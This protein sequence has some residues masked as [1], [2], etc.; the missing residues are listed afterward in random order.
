METIIRR[1]K[2]L[3]SDKRGVSNALVVLLSLILITV[4]VS[5]V[6]IW[7]YQMNQLDWERTNESVKIPLVERDFRL[8][9]CSDLLG[10]FIER[11]TAGGNWLFYPVNYIPIGG[12]QYLSGS[13]SD[14]QNNTGNYLRFGSFASNTQYHL[15]SRDTLYS[16]NSTQYQDY[17]SLT[18]TAENQSDYLILAYIEV[19]HSSSSSQAQVRFVQDDTTLANYL[20]RPRVAN[21]EVM[22][23]MFA[24][25]YRGTGN[26]VNFK[27]QI[28]TSAGGATVT[29]LRGRIYA[30]R[31]DNLPNTEYSSTYYSN[32]VTNV[33]NVWGDTSLDTFEII[34]NPVSSGYYLIWASAKVESDS[35]ASSVAV[36]LNI[37][38][39][40]EYVPYLV[41]GETTW[42]YARIEDT[43]LAE[44]HCFAVMA[45]R[46]FQPGAHS[47]KFQIADID[48]T[49]S[50]DWQYISLLAIRL[51]DVFEFYTA[52]TTI[53]AQTTQTT[54]QTYTSLNIPSGNAGDYL[55]LGSIV[56]RGSSINYDYETAIVIDGATYGRQQIRPKDINDYVPK[57]FMQNI[58]FDDS[59]HTVAT[60]Y[61]TLSS[62]MT[63]FVKNSDILAIRLPRVQQ[64]IEVEFTG[65]SNLENWVSLAWTVDSRFTTNDVATTFQL[66]RTGGYPSSGEGYY[67]AMIGASDITVSQLVTTNPEDFRD[68]VTSEWKLKIKAVKTTATPFE[69]WIDFVELKAESPSE[70]YSLSIIGSVSGCP[71]ENTYSIEAYIHFRANDAGEDWILKAYNWIS[72]KYDE[73]ASL[74]PT[75]HFEDYKVSFGD[76]WQH[77]VNL[78]NG[79]IRLLFHDEKPDENPTMLEIEFFA[80]KVILKHGAVFIFENKGAL[81]A[82]IVAIWVNNATL[83]SR[84]NTD[85]FI[86]PGET[87]TYKNEVID[88]PDGIFMVKIV[89]EKGNMVVFVGE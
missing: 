1:L 57:V 70:N 30:I 12:T 37:D 42:S 41:G 43:N 33:N 80:I 81:T 23:Q 88:I 47:I 82:H 16:T 29:A 39:G 11:G 74:S 89:T 86:N 48:T 73:I 15:A 54:L 55:I 53:Q 34:I 4:I 5:N 46:L 18:F 63:V 49:P 40:A 7:S 17:L 60:K 2:T 27:W 84:F 52:S 8:L 62:S 21:T 10:A 79:T 71:L 68:P 85:L 6:V 77:Y 58:T 45:I 56:T 35:T 50:A 32:E 51:T 75:L 64:T 66:Y 65:T 72:G 9:N 69:L 31:L 22:P 20:D 44:E 14:L 13:I 19:T 67:H 83:H 87:L 26:I 78:G 61:R 38:N 3:V 24:Y 59:S 25:I 36:R 28:S 76:N